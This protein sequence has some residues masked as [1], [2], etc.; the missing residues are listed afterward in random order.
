MGEW[1]RESER[2]GG[3][4]DEVDGSVGKRI[5]GTVCRIR[6]TGDIMLIASSPAEI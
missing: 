6:G 5:L 2:G 4:P 1:E 3:E